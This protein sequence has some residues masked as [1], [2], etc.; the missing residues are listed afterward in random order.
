MSKNINKKW[1]IIFIFLLPFAAFE[2]TFK[3]FVFKEVFDYFEAANKL[4]LVNLIIFTIGGY[5]LIMISQ[6]LYNFTVHQIIFMKISAL[7]QKIFKVFIY[8]DNLLQEKNTASYV[9]F[10][11]NDL[12]LIQTNYYDSLLK[13]I[14]NLI[15]FFISISAI[16]FLNSTMAI[17]LIVVFII[18]SL[19]PQLFKKRIV[20]QTED[21]TNK[22]EI[23]T[24]K[25]KD[26]FTGIDTIRG[27]GMEKRMID[28]HIT[29]NSTVERSFATLNN[30]RVL[31]D[32]IVGFFGLC[33]FFFVNLYGIILATRGDITI[34][35]VLAIIQLSNTVV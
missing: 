7:K 30:W 19:I 18:P 35:T 31:S 6:T 32:N 17:L 3:A 25:V 16:F 27:Y 20:N 11:L 15:I 5:F 23:Y 26:A 10:L 34:G 33:G 8:S 2:N 21:W 4:P 28:D 24:G 12:K 9:S 13:I 1:L 22:N 29:Y 14:L